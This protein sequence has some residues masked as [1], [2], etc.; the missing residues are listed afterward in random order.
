MRW[1]QRETEIVRVRLHGSSDALVLDDVQSGNRGMSANCSHCFFVSM[2]E[3][4]IFRQVR[5]QLMMAYEL[6]K[7]THS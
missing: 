5:E 7:M 1:R 3:G 4:D 2:V 6:F